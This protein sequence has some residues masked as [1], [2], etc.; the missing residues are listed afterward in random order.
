MIEKTIGSATRIERLTVGGDPAF[1]ITGADHGFAYL[2]PG[3]DAAF[4]TQRLAGPTLLV[5][6]ADGVLL[7]VEGE[8]SREEAV[9]IAESFR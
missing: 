5:E 6:R 7:R 8:L 4:E 2:L 1:F 9:R 3:G